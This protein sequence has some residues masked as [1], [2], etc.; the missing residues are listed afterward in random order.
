MTKRGDLAR[1]SASYPD[2]LVRYRF[3]L[4]ELAS[5]LGLPG[6]PGPEE[7]VPQDVADLTSDCLQ[8]FVDSRVLGAELAGKL[9]YLV[10][11]AIDTGARTLG[12]FSALDTVKLRLAA[13]AAGLDHPQQKEMRIVH[14]TLTFEEARRYYDWKGTLVEMRLGVGLDR[15]DPRSLFNV[16]VPDA[17]LGFRSTTKVKVVSRITAP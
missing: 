13:N 17:N 12:D 15:A 7:G 10:E 9:A 11:E 2:L 5:R 8:A 16:Y 4:S 1:H 6:M 3:I 14:P